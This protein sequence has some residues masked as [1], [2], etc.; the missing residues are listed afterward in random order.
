MDL[1]NNLRTHFVN[2]GKTIVDIDA[3]FGAVFAD[4]HDV[5]WLIPG[6]VL[7]TMPLD[8]RST[9]DAVLLR[10]DQIEHLRERALHV[11]RH[12][13]ASKG[14]CVDR[15]T[16]SD[17]GIMG[18]GGVS[19]SIHVGACVTRLALE[20]ADV[21]ALVH[22]L[23]EHSLLR[24]PPSR[25]RMDRYLAID[26]PPADEKTYPVETPTVQLLNGIPSIL[27][28]MGLC[29]TL[30]TADDRTLASPDSL[31]ARLEQRGPIADAFMQVHARLPHVDVSYELLK[32][33]IN[34]RFQD[35]HDSY[36][37]NPRDRS[38]IRA[39][40]SKGA[41]AEGNELADEFERIN[42]RRIAFIS[43]IEHAAASRGWFKQV[44]SIFMRE[45]VQLRLGR[46]F[47][48]VT[49]DIG[50]SLSRRLANETPVEAIEAIIA[51]QESDLARECITLIEQNDVH[52]WRK[53]QERNLAPAPSAMPLPML[54][55]RV[56][57]SEANQI[58]LWARDQVRSWLASDEALRHYGDSDYFDPATDRFLSE[59]D[60]LEVANRY[61]G[62]DWHHP[63]AIRIL[64]EF[65]DRRADT[66][67]RDYLMKAEPHHEVGRD[68]IYLAWRYRNALP[69]IG[70]KW[71]APQPF[72]G[73]P[74]AETRITFG[75]PIA[76]WAKNDDGRDAEDL[77]DLEDATNESDEVPDSDP[78]RRK[79]MAWAHH[80]WRWCPPSA[81]P[82]KAA[83]ERGWP[84]VADALEANPHLVRML[85]TG[86]DRG[87]D[88][89]DEPGLLMGEDFLL[90]WSR[91][92]PNLFL[93][94]LVAAALKADLTAEMQRVQDEA[95]K[96]KPELASTAD[97]VKDIARSQTEHIRTPL[98]IA[99]L[100]CRQACAI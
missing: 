8:D 73:V 94:R 85:L 61:L 13:L 67:A 58:D 98:A 24:H 23:F 44:A 64:L 43:A 33:C 86:E 42:Q 50:P 30:E 77:A 41:V 95:I 10:F 75:D 74:Y 83:R 15:T 78:L 63:T 4:G 7:S 72:D 89:M 80:N 62:A 26:G 79:L 19:S 69:E 22:K 48:E 38:I 90:A 36:S 57:P 34:L 17:W 20:G 53:A 45:E 14:Y 28:M 47:R 54:L 76:W 39:I 5:C 12:Y 31:A 71:F 66:L 25:R 35:G 52:T 51:P 55:P 97:L 37:L 32:G 60:W 65:G 27:K 29:R 56:E 81:S 84:E 6:D 96:R 1:L 18:E 91:L 46:R 21:Y 92:N 3:G 99:W 87:I 100:R 49:I 68:E 59:R 9:P 88:Q 16:R 40:R 93:A 70:R 11:A 82:L 2:R